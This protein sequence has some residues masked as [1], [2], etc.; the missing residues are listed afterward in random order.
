MYLHIHRNDLIGHSIRICM[1]VI[2][3]IYSYPYAH[4][5]YQGIELHRQQ[6]KLSKQM[7]VKDIF[8]D[9]SVLRSRNLV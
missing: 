3:S 9:T 4:Y 5:G 2:Y 7:M 6:I 1:A 8:V